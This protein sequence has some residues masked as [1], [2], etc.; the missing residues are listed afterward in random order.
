MSD[1]PK[2]QI[3]RSGSRCARRCW[4]ECRREDHLAEMRDN[5]SGACLAAF[6]AGHEHLED[7]LEASLRPVAEGCATD[8]VGYFEGIYVRPG[9]RRRGI[10]RALMAAA[11]EWAI[12]RGCTEMASDCLLDNS[13]SEGFHREVGT[14]SWSPSLIF[15]APFRGKAG[16]SYSSGPAKKKI[17]VRTALATSIA[18]IDTTTELVVD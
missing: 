16:R 1:A 14:R 7:F 11:E 2:R 3:S 18:M 5:I 13:D 17:A 8:P 12:S 4:P 15:D 6:V 9:C 10:G